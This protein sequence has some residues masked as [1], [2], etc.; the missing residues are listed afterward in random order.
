MLATINPLPKSLIRKYAIFNLN[1][2]MSN[3]RRIMIVIILLM[4]VIGN[5]LV[6]D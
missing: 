1:N 5:P 6:V 4:F 3:P 2:I